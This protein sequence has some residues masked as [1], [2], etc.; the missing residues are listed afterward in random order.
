MPLELSDVDGDETGAVVV[1]LGGGGGGRAPVA[2]AFDWLGL[3]SINFTDELLP[4]AA[5]VPALPL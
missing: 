2:D 5:G 3:S 4:A 1:V